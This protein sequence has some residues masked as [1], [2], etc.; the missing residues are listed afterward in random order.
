MG[1]LGG[2]GRQQRAAG[3]MRARCENCLRTLRRT[4]GERFT[5][6]DTFYRGLEYRLL[7]FVYEQA[8]E[9]GERSALKMNL[10]TR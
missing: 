2:A 1:R 9:I 3:L 8:A 6:T 5:I 10:E 4:L 7:D